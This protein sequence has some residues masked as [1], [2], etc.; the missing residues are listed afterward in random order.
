[1]EPQS[2]THRTLEP[3]CFCQLLIL[4]LA[5][6]TTL[7]TDVAPLLA[8]LVSQTLPC[9]YQH[10]KTS[11]PKLTT[12]RL[13]LTVANTKGDNI[14]PLIVTSSSPLP[15]A[16]MPPQASRGEVGIVHSRASVSISDNME[17]PSQLHRAWQVDNK[18]C[19]SGILFFACGAAGVAFLLAIPAVITILLGF[20]II[21]IITIYILQD[22]MPAAQSEIS[23]HKHFTKKSKH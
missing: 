5:S 11:P 17:F 10:C 12:S 16:P 22:R 4:F 19:D 6:D 20:I 13:I 15:F 1:M 9:Y 2:D 18:G 14:T 3:R 7:F 23:D 8:M 21:I